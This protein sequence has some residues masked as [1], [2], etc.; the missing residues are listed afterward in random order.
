MAGDT[1][2]AYARLKRPPAS[3]EPPCACPGSPPIVLQ[4]RLEPNPLVC[5]R[6]NAEVPP[7]SVP[8]PVDLV[9]EIA[10]WRDV[11]DALFM[12]WMDCGEY[13]AW[14][15][16]QL[17][18]PQNAVHN[19][20]LALIAKLNA[21]RP[22]YYWWFTDQVMQPEPP[23]PACPRCGSALER[24]GPVRVCTLCRIVVMP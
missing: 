10:C 5:L 9:D 1:G 12:L 22:T 16:G 2:D 7:E 3:G 17:K 18:A 14:A 6:C 20:G 19:R 15:K 21:V 13:E 11:H 8:V 24:E 4:G 23:L